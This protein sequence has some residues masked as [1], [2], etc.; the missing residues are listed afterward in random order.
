MNNIWILEKAPYGDVYF[1]RTNR[2][3]F[4]NLVKSG[5]YRD[6]SILNGDDFDKQCYISVYDEPWL[7]V[8]RGEEY[9][10]L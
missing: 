4:E 1:W 5:H 3:D 9:R 10:F 8:I 7:I 2:E 6:Y